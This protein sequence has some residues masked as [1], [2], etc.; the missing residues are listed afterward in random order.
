MEAGPFVP[1][2]GCGDDQVSGGQVRVQSA[3]GPKEQ[4]FLRALD[5]HL[6]QNPHRGG[7]AEGGEVQPKG[8]S[9]VGKAV[10]GYF[11]TGVYGADDLHWKPLLQR[12]YNLSLK[13]HK[14]G[15]REALHRL[16]EMYRFQQLL[17][18]VKSMAD[19]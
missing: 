18:A 15:F 17:A 19:H 2:G 8:L 14:H 12:I 13:G 10:N 4:D 5:P 3:A 9:L 11:H 16:C 7:A 1:V 6:L